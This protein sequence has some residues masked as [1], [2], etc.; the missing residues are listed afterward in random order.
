MPRGSSPKRERQ[1]E[2]IKKSAQRSGRYGKRAEEVAD[3]FGAVVNG[4]LADGGEAEAGVESVRGGIGW[5][6]IDFA[7]DAAVAG[8][9]ASFEEIEIESAGVTFA[10]SG[11]GNNDSIDVNE[12]VVAFTEP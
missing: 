7:D 9:F 3:G 10:A 11:E 6:E 12:A 1:Y 2:H 8:G 5:I 4:G